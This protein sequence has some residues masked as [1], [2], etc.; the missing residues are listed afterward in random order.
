MASGKEI[1]IFSLD[2]STSFSLTTQY[3]FRAEKEVGGIRSY[4]WSKRL[5][6]PVAILLRSPMESP[7]SGWTIGVA[8]Y[9]YLMDY[10]HPEYFVKV[11]DDIQGHLI[12][13]VFDPTGEYVLVAQWICNDTETVKCSYKNIP[14]YTSN[15]TDT[16]LTLV[17]WRTGEKYELFRL[18]EIATENL[19]A[20]GDL[21]WSADGSTILV[22]RFDA[23]F[24]VLKVK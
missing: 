1:K 8:S 24:I 7:K 23:P 6:M 20:S 16:I 11:M 10:E 5:D 9:A 4:L 2:G 3:D 15:V 12:G 13:A 18:S 14:A 19:A 22:G 17:R 21:V